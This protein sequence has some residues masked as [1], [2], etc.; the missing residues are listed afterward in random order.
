MSTYSDRNYIL[1][2]F[3]SMAVVFTMLFVVDGALAQ[4]EMFLT[5][6]SLPFPPTSNLPWALCLLA[7]VLYKGKLKANPLS[8][9]TVTLACYAVFELFFLSSGPKYDLGDI[10]A[11]MG[12]Y[13]IPLILFGIAVAV[14]IKIDHRRILILLLFLFSASLVFSALQFFTDSP[15]LP[16][17][18]SDGKFSVAS[19]GFNDKVRAFSLFH[20]GMEAGIF[21]CLTAGIGTSMLLTRKRRLAGIVIL[22][23]SAFGCFSTYTR[24]TIIGFLACLLTVFVLRFRPLKWLAPY[25][26]IVWGVLAIVVILQAATMSG[27][28]SRVDIASASSFETRLFEWRIHSATYL[29][30]SASQILFGT[31]LSQW[32]PVT[33]P[34]RLNTA[35]LISIDN[36]YLEIL[37]HSGLVGLILVVYFCSQVWRLL[38]ARAIK[39]SEDY[40]L[41]SAALFSVL[42]FFSS[43]NDMSPQ[44][45]MACL[46]AMFL[47]SPEFNELPVE[48]TSEYAGAPILNTSTL[49]FD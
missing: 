6:G 28:A 24:L 29:S 45:F 11:S 23:T 42:P 33:D 14:P 26:P 31:G 10:R 46:L 4:F 48:D 2:F 1:L 20:S 41:A 30:G 36:A 9:A 25:M 37:L 47:P 35:A 34:S 19:V 27:G 13:M 17:S 3:S 44:V 16:T 15:V 39:G 21:Y 32:R 12:T 7:I 22:L 43:I 5:G 40:V 49:Q 38:Y 8:L 18:S